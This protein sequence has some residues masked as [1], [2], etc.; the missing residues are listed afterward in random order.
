MQ[1]R[2][3]GGKYGIWGVNENTSKMDAPVDPLRYGMGTAK[4]IQDFFGKHYE[5]RLNSAKASLEEGNL[6]K[7]NETLPQEIAALNAKYGAD[8]KYYPQIQAANLQKEQAN[9]KEIMARTGLSY[10][11]A[12]VAMAHLP[13]IQAQTRN[14][15]GK[16]NPLNTA[17]ALFKAYQSAPQGSDQRALY[18]GLLAKEVGKEGMQFLQG[19]GDGGGSTSTSPGSSSS[20]SQTQNG[21]IETNPLGGGPRATFH[22]GYDQQT[23]QTLESPTTTSAGRNQTRSE[24][25]SE[26]NYIAPELQKGFAPYMGAMGSLKLTK[27]SFI[28][29]N[30][31]N[32]PA[33][34]A[35]AKRL[36]AYSLANRLKREAANVISRQSAGQAPGVEAA[37]EQEQ[38][39]FGSLP[40]PL[41]SSFIPN[42]IQQSSLAQYFPMQEEMANKAIETE[43]VGYPQSGATPQ[44][45]NRQPNSDRGFLGRPTGNPSQSAPAQS[46]QNAP[47]QQTEIQDPSSFSS[48]EEAQQYYQ[49]LSPEQKQAFLAKL[50][51]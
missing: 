46:P 8:E 32:S 21:Q 28:A 38:S 44:W 5:N 30:S 14:E 20:V 50:G 4:G 48:K 2:S 51:G 15:I 11:Q 25:N 26:L 33:G 10:A 24:A 19:G 17:D 31:P 49:S 22:Q 40:G 13:L 16:G 45:A 35:A 41:A 27:D 34:K 42:S 1:E 37:R 43:R 6:K 12:K 7:Q 9:V 18:E 23:G 3:G 39:S 47:Q 36:E 29:S